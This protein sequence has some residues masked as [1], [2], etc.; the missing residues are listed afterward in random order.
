[1]R[2]PLLHGGAID[3]NFI[4]WLG[5]TFIEP[6]KE[7]QGLL[8]AT[9]TEDPQYRTLL[10]ATAS[11]Y[12]YDL[13]ENQ[14]S[15]SAGGAGGV[16]GA[17]GITLDHFLVAQARRETPPALGPHGRRW[18]DGWKHPFPGGNKAQLARG[19]WRGNIASNFL[20]DPK[21]VWGD[22]AVSV[23]RHRILGIMGDGNCFYRALGVAMILHPRLI[24]TLIDTLDAL[25]YAAPDVE[26]NV[27]EDFRR[28]LG[29]SMTYPLPEH[30][31]DIDN[32]IIRWK[33]DHRLLVRRIRK[34]AQGWGKTKTYDQ[35]PGKPTYDYVQ[36][37]VRK[38]NG[39]TWLDAALVR[40]MRELCAQRLEGAAHHFR[41]NVIS[42]ANDFNTAVTQPMSSTPHANIAEKIRSARNPVAWYTQHV[43]RQMWQDASGAAIR[44]LLQCLDMS[45]G[46]S[47]SGSG[48]GSVR[49]RGGW[50]REIPRI[51]MIR[52]SSSIP[53]DFGEGLTTVDGNTR[54]HHLWLWH[55]GEHFDVC[56]VP[57]R[58]E[59]GA[60]QRPSSRGG[61][62]DP[63]TGSATEGFTSD[64]HA[65][66][67]RK[68]KRAATGTNNPVCVVDLT[69]AARPRVFRQEEQSPE[70]VRCICC[71]FW[72]SL[73]QLQCPNCA[74]NQ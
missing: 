26:R 12:I 61:E 14:W 44:A 48:S 13:V 39:K 59:M 45:I 41:I 36:R 67:P 46:A 70:N 15:R 30:I 38:F 19:I 35:R 24:S 25:V 9:D 65:S 17:A 74:T 57:T 63:F 64:P 6:N 60:H 62:E 58:Q 20:Q 4:E 66:P 18:R 10:T 52:G 55:H 1:M 11:E 16:G 8:E 43:V 32:E 33:T 73:D 47:G 49:K 42:D 27:P 21:V 3:R 2:Q 53:T 31:R 56:N 72:L 22:T 51:H 69:G 29:L 68:K 71:Q 5:A 40:A 28:Y 54:V 23:A 37:V 50:Q 34:Y 7:R